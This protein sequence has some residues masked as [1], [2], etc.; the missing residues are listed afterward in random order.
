MGISIIVKGADFSNKNIGQVTPSSVVNL[1]GLSISGPSTV[2]GD[3]ADFSVAYIP[4]NTTQRGVVW[5][6]E[7]GSSY[8]S[9]DA[10]TGKL[11][12]LSGADGD[13]VVIK[14]TSSYDNTIFATK[15]V[16]VTYI[17][18][19]YHYDWAALLET[20]Q[21][22]W[23]AVNYNSGVDGWKYRFIIAND[24]SKIGQSISA[25]KSGGNDYGSLQVFK[26]PCAG[27]S[28]MRVPVFKST[29]GYG[30]A[31]T[32][33]SDIVTGLYTNSTV[34]TGTY[35]ELTVPAGTAYL[36]MTLSKSVYD[37]LGEDM[38]VEQTE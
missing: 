33:S 22:D 18:N 2:E 38:V 1:L 11:T 28:K 4:S 12:I 7:S 32:D 13:D 20:N 23:R 19:Y 15:T 6:I 34:E 14:A 27:A 16:N 8:A 24:N 21:T 25:V 5:N 37:V 29:S 3:E 31:F 17:A 30:Y 35:Q 36:W 9:I 10:S 26:I